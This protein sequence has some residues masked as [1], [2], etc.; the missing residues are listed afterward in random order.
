VG[1]RH[2]QRDGGED[3]RHADQLGKNIFQNGHGVLSFLTKNS[4][5]EQVNAS[6]GEG[7]CIIS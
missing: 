6:G 1:R 3:Q 7:I 2:I 5:R 4:E